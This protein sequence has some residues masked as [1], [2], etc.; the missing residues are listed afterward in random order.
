MNLIKN[1][2]IKNKILIGIGLSFILAMIFLMSIVIYQFNSLSETNESLI[3]DELLEREYVQYENL[4]KTRAKILAEIYNFYAIGENLIGKN[5]SE[6][7]LKSL[8]SHFN[9]NSDLIDNYYFI[10]DLSGT[11]ISLLPSPALEGQNRKNLEIHDRK[12]LAEMIN[13]I[14]EKNSGRIS[15]PY[16]NPKTEEIETKYGYVQ[17]IEGTDMFVG[18]GAYHSNYNNIL[19]QLLTKIFNIRTKT[20]YLLL[21]TFVIIISIIFLIIFNI[22]KYINANLEKMLLAF[23]KIEKGQLKFQLDKNSKDEFGKLALGFNKMI[24]RIRLLTYNDPLTGLP[25]LRFLE[26]QLQ[27]SIKANECEKEKIYLFIL[28]TDNLSLINSNYGY[29]KGNE[30]LK[31]LFQRL[32][33]RLL[34]KTIIARKNDELIFYFKSDKSKKEIEKYANDIL[35]ILSKPYKIENNLIYLDLEMG[36]AVSDKNEKYSELIRKSRLALYFVDQKNN[37]KF[38]DESMLGQ[39]SGKVS[40][41]RELRESIQKNDFKLHY[42]PQLE[43]KTNKIIGVE[44]LIRSQRLKECGLSTEKFISL[45]EKTGMIVE[46]GDWILNESLKQLK[47]WHNKGYKNLSISVNIAPQ[48]LQE[49]GFVSKIENLL[50]KHQIKGKYLEIEITERTA[51]KDVNYTIKLLNEFKKLGVLISIDDF[52]TGYSSFEYLNKFALDKLKIDKSFVQNTKNMNIVKAIILMGKTLGLKV[53][54][55][56]VETKAELEYLTDNNCDYY[57][58]YYFAK[59]EKAAE[60]EKYFKKENTDY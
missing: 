47:I 52:G 23:K 17:K 27:Q 49:S 31:L 25:N 45:A 16:L 50:K 4:V 5:A 14:K 24:S 12:V 54:A 58:G 8:I 36:I 42:Q 22:S 26:N 6:S 33:K 19:K 38:F 9:K 13:I 34:E 10:Y 48:Q 37:I 29:Q 2:S 30:I 46:L 44:V 35:N 55:E 28:I 1:I 20:I 3:R 32:N 57:Q 15:Y 59:A 43:C 53:V 18:A 60:V 7:E 40:L 39:L 11:T 56:G 21:F 41:E 51:I